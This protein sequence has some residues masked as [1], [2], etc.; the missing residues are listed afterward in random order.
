MGDLDKEDNNDWR[1]V[2]KT[3]RGVLQDSYKELT[4]AN[5]AGLD[6]RR[7]FRQEIFIAAITLLT[8][9]TPFAGNYV[10]KEGI[11]WIAY[12]GLFTSVVL[13]IFF[14]EQEYKVH[15]QL[16]SF[17]LKQLG[18]ALDLL[19]QG[20]EEKHVRE[21]IGEFN[22]MKHV[23]LSTMILGYIAPRATAF[24]IYLFIASTILL[25]YSLVPLDVFQKI[26]AIWNR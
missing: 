2:G 16:S 15:M 23:P 26:G 4:E 3:I 5:N 9:A 11:F 22:K 14:V 1:N 20:K 10:S 17:G 13:G 25:A 21:A 8:I 6:Q 7:S 18:K 24:S 12:I 19:F